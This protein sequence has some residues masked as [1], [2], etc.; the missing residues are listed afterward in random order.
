MMKAIVFLGA[1][2]IASSATVTAQVRSCVGITDAQARLT[3]FDEQSK[4]VPSEK[5]AK[6]SLTARHL[7]MSE[8]LPL[9]ESAFD[10][11]IGRNEFRLRCDRANPSRIRHCL[12]RPPYEFRP[13]ASIHMQVVP[14]LLR[15]EKNSPIFTSRIE[16]GSFH[17]RPLPTM[18]VCLAP[19]RVSD[20]DDF[21]ESA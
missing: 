15:Q 17:S 19:A 11:K 2:L 6:P 18:S 21:D 9:P 13:F 12:F 3:C 5:P 20:P 4:K 16:S 10:Q 14:S 8:S 7:L 1:L